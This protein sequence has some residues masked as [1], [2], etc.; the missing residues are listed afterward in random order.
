MTITATKDAQ[1]ERLGIS[2]LVKSGKLFVHTISP[3]SPFAKTDLEVNDMV[4]A[5]N[6]TDFLHNPDLN[7]ALSLVKAAPET[8]TFVVRR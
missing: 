7:Q 5:I 6:G 1:D 8:I 2:L 4:E 3:T